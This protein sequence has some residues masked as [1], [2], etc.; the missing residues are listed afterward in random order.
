[1][2]LQDK[3]LTVDLDNPKQLYDFELLNCVNRPFKTRVLGTSLRSTASFT[4]SKRQQ[5][6][7]LDLDTFGQVEKKT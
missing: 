6:L 7:Q 1:M 4:N 3:T 2:N 5:N